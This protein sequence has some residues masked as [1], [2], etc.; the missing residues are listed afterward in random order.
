MATP[1]PRPPKSRGARIV[2]AIAVLNFVILL[3]PPLT[4]F[5]GQ[6]GVWFFLITGVIGVLSLLVMY[7]VDASAGKD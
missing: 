1:V 4:W 5:V 2:L 3:F 6:G 7:R